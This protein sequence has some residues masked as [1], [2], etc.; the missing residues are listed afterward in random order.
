MNKVLKQ[1]VKKVYKAGFF[2]DITP[3]QNRVTFRNCHNV[4]FC[5][6]LTPDKSIPNLGLFHAGYVHQ[7]Q[8]LK[9][10]FESEY[11]SLGMVDMAKYTP[12]YMQETDNPDFILRQS[13]HI[14]LN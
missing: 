7:W 3:E 1:I 14:T 10:T 5:F 8:E 11:N 6:D 9:P 4:L 2:Y 13:K 12:F